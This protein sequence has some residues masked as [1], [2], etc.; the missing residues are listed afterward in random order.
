IQVR[1]EHFAQEGKQVALEQVLPEEGVQ[2]ARPYPWQVTH[3]HGQADEALRCSVRGVLQR[4]AVRL[5]VEGGHRSA[6]HPHIELHERP[7]SGESCCSARTS[8]RVRRYPRCTI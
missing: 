7:C 6:V 3:G 5:A 4:K 8:S 1:P 2:V